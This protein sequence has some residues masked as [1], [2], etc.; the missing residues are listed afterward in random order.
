MEADDVVGGDLADA[1]GGHGDSQACA[2]EAED[3]E[4]L[5]GL[6][7]DARAEAFFDAG[8][9]ALLVG[10]G[11]GGGG[12]EDEGLV[13]ELAGGDGL[14]ARERV[15]GGDHR[16]QGLGEEDFDCDAGGGAAVAEK[17]GV[18]SLVGEQFED[19]GGVGLVELQMDLGEAAAVLAEHGGQRGEHGGADE[20]DAEEADLAAAD[21]AGLVEVLLDVAESAAGALEED[22]AGAGEADGA[23][24]A[25]EEGVAEDI[26]ELADLLGEGWLGE[27]EALG[28]AT[29]VELFGDGYEVA[30]VAE[31]DVAI[32][33]QDIIIRTNKILD[34]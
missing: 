14:F 21:A 24:G 27:V 7:D 33:I 9:D 32:H 26:L 8:S 31:F 22:L 5:R 6:L 29:E 3:G 1:G 17:A 2:D 30:Q 20:P 12:E 16:D 11:A 25:S 19:P 18:E 34:I 15:T 13:A 23:G 10:V 4:P 28:G